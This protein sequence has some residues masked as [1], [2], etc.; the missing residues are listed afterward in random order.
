ML[1]TYD[2][3][4]DLPDGETL[5]ITQAAPHDV[6]KED[7]DRIV[8][9]PISHITN[10]CRTINEA[11]DYLAEYNLMRERVNEKLFGKIPS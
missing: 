6:P 7:V 9:Y 11:Q 3:H 8:K 10:H 4:V 5:H 2:Y 1:I